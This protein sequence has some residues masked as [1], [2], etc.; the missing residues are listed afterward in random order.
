MCED[1]EALMIAIGRVRVIAREIGRLCKSGELSWEETGD[2]VQSKCQELLR[3]TEPIV[4]CDEI[5]KNV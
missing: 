4:F 2:K 1:R 5:G 3:L